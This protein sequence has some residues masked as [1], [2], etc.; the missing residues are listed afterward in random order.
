VEIN[1]GYIRE[2]AGEQ[3]LGVG[4]ERFWGCP[5]ATL[6]LL[7]NCAALTM[8]ANKGQQITLRKLF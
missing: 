8:R 3:Y 7:R 4:G 5:Q 6:A 2:V 1:D